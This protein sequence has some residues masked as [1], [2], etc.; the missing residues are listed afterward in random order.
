MLYQITTYSTNSCIRFVSF[1]K[2]LHIPFQQIGTLARGK[3]IKHELKG[4]SEIATPSSDL[5]GCRYRNGGLQ[6]ALFQA[7]DPFF[8]SAAAWVLA[9][10]R[11]L[12]FQGRVV[13]GGPRHGDTARGTGTHRV[14]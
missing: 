11:D 3:Q 9:L 14:R 2:L 5:F 12:Q 10:P 1:G 7:R 4:V 13:G 6:L 8:W